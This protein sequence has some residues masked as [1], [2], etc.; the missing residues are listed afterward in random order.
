MVK[1]FVRHNTDIKLHVL[2]VNSYSIIFPWADEN[3]SDVKFSC[4]L[5]KKY[6]ISYSLYLITRTFPCVCCYSLCKVNYSNDH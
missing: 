1:Y 4:D 5:H 6:E 3:E 2:Y